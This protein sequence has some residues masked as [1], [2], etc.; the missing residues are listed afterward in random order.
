LAKAAFL[1]RDGVLNIDTGYP[2]KL[3]ELEIIPGVPAALKLLSE[4]GF[5]LFI[6][7]NQSGVGKGMFDETDVVAFNNRLLYLLGTQNIHFRGVSYCTHVAAEGCL[8]RKPEPKMI[9]DFVEKFSLDSNESMLIGDKD[10]DVT[11]GVRA[12]LNTNL[13]I[14]S[15]T[16]YALL[17]AVKGFLEKK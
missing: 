10:S 17:N 5:Q 14:P 15:N 9:L 3:T 1:D 6:V 4:A 7:S 16:G 12:G 2:H 13:K 11:A 8:C